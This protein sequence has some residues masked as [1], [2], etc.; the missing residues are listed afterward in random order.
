MPGGIVTLS[1][2]LRRERGHIPP[3][4]A[5]RERACQLR[6]HTGADP[7]LLRHERR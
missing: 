3:S 6:G 5:P 4:V 2:L 1:I 7:D